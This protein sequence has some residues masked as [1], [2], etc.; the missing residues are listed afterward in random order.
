MWET[1]AAFFLFALFF[2]CLPLLSGLSKPCFLPPGHRLQPREDVSK[3]HVP[4]STPTNHASAVQRP[5]QGLR[6][7]LLQ[8]DEHARR[9]ACPPKMPN[10]QRIC[11]HLPRPGGRCVRRTARASSLSGPSFANRSARH[12]TTTASCA[13]A[14][15]NVLVWSA[16]NKYLA[17]WSHTG[18]ATTTHVASRHAVGCSRTRS[19]TFP[20]SRARVSFERSFGLLRLLSSLG[21]GEFLEYCYLDVVFQFSP[22]WNKHGEHLYANLFDDNRLLLLPLHSSSRPSQTLPPTVVPFPPL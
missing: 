18:A 11:A 7:R 17:R 5:R 15:S 10:R 20:V 2:G 12:C 1:T 4:A 9:A 22:N 21:F 3:R 8:D 13:Q 19:F 6:P 16:C 14:N